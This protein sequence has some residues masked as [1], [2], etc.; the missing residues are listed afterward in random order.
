MILEY[1]RPETME[2][3]MRLLRRSTPKTLPLGGG[4][5]VSQKSQNDFAVVDL[6]NLHLDG[7]HPNG[8]DLEIG[9]TVRLEDLRTC[10]FLQPALRDAVHSE[11]AINMRRMASIAGTIVTCNGRSSVGTTL[12]ALDAKLIWAPG[13]DEIA[14][15]NYLPLRDTWENGQLIQAVKIPLNA[16]LAIEAVRRTPLD[17]PIIFVAVC[18]WPSGRTRVALGGTGRAPILAMDGS[19][20]T[21]AELAVK[22]AFLFATDAWAEAD[23]RSTVSSQITRRLVS[24]LNQAKGV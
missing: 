22:D 1:H 12:L 16:R 19:D 2:D 10:E 7:I 20:A 3:A 23:Y 11:T 21:G 24:E 5:I 14:I 4:T 18:M 13:G 8:N 17:R 15:G 9:A 6:Q